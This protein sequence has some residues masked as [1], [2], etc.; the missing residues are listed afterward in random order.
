MIENYQVIRDNRYY[1]IRTLDGDF[2]RF[3]REKVEELANALRISE[4]EATI[5]RWI[6]FNK[7]DNSTD[8]NVFHLSTEKI[9]RVY[10]PIIKYCKDDFENF[11]GWLEDQTLQ[12]VHSPEE[13]FLDD[14]DII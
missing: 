1:T 11:I 7:E 14:W 8:S 12:V 10:K 5:L 9:I 13:T 3:A 2:K 6:I 4:G